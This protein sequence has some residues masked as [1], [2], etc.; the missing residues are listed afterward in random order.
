[1]GIN[2]YIIH[3][4]GRDRGQKFA[5]SHVTCDHD[6]ELLTEKVFLLDHIVSDQPLKLLER[7]AYKY[8]YSE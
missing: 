1:M 6:L 8:S 5:D 3:F 7:P 2:I 4:S